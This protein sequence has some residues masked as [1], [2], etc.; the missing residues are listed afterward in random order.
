MFQK[1][2]YTLKQLAKIIFFFLALS[3]AS[4]HAQTADVIVY[5]GTAGGVTAAIAGARE[6]ASVLLVEPVQHVGGMVTGGL[7]H[8]VYGDRALIGLSSPADHGGRPKIRC[9]RAMP[10]PSC[11]APKQYLRL[12]FLGP[13]FPKPGITRCTAGGHPPLT[14]HPMHHW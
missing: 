11:L 4:V 9:Y 10:S 6:G 3:F 1:F 8:T 12:W 13:I 14:T 7:S 5:G 2:P